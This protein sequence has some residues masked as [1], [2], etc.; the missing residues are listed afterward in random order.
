M[1]PRFITA[2]VGRVVQLLGAVLTGIAVLFVLVPGTGM[3]FL[4]AG[5]QSLL[6]TGVAALLGGTLAWLYG[7]P[8]LIIKPAGH[9]DSSLE[10]P[11]RMTR[12]DAALVTALTWIV[13]ALVA[14]TPFLLWAWFAADV[15]DAHPFRSA[16]NCFFES[17]S[18]LTTTGATV[19]SDIEAMHAFCGLSQVR[20]AYCSN[21]S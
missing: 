9:V 11:Y 13:G 14:G 15:P 5:E 19:L 7:K 1:N 6:I 18:G 2:H 21:C 12:R 3:R 17:I 4:D 16:I 20:P 8:A 10:R